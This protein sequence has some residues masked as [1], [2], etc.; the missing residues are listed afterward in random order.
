MPVQDQDG[1]SIK[2]AIYQLGNSVALRLPGQK[3][4]WFTRFSGDLLA[5][6]VLKAVSAA[7]YA[8]STP[9]RHESQQIGPRTTGRPA[10]G[11]ARTSG[12]RPLKLRNGWIVRIRRAS[13]GPPPLP[14]GTYG[15]IRT[16]SV[17]KSFK[18]ETNYRDFDGVTRRV[19]RRAKSKR[20][21][22]D[23]LKEAL[24][25]RVRVAT[26][27][28]ITDQT[29]VNVV[30][31]KWLRELDESSKATRTKKTYRESWDRD[32]SKAV[33]ELRVRE[34]T[35]G[36]ADRTLQ[37]IKD[38]AGLGSAKHAK[39]V[40]S[41]ILGLAV[42]FDALATNPVREVGAFGEAAKK[43]KA[44][45]KFV[46]EPDE[47]PGLRAHLR[48]S[49]LAKR[50]DL[51]DLVDFL[52]AVGCRI[53]EVL[54]LDWAKVDHAERTI[55]IEG[56]VIRIAGVGLVVQPHTKSKAGMRTI[57][58][59]EWAAAILRRRAE[60]ATS[61]WAFPSSKGTLRDPDNTR[62]DLRTA[63]EGTDWKGCIRT[64]SGTSSRPCS[65]RRA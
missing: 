24:R 42:R 36:V 15:E 12:I 48:A 38:K 14:V 17:G 4:V 50:R 44:A 5:S 49:K 45:D 62:K 30:A 40:L 43:N 55:V 59:P 53:G 41:G 58:V 10:A 9:G 54:A 61:E 27:D 1:E 39:V 33:G 21:A 16:Y 56:T 13:D 47:L 31:E 32:L 51:V 25:D 26:G 2:L 65:T 20:A 23:T 34:V 29:R 35:V 8:V 46:L 37:A 18:A 52:S 57:R 63:V 28:E 7:T 3:P 64:P 22:I 11:S 60:V 6:L 19:E